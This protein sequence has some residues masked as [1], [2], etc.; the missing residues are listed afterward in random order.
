MTKST[1]LFLSF[2]ILFLSTYSFGQNHSKFSFSAGIGTLPT[3]FADDA[4]VNTPPVNARLTYHA[5]PNFSLSAYAGYSS[6]TTNSP[7]VVSDGQLS[8]L[9]NKQTVAGLRGEMKKMVGKKFKVYGGALLGYSFADKR[10]FDKVT[11]E[12]IE[13]KI[14][15]PTP[16]DPNASNKTFLYS[17]FVGTT[18]YFTKGIGVFAEIGYGISLL[19]TGVT[20]NI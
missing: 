10:E 11:G 1:Q 17:G 2:C 19:N 16:Y 9:E 20:L 3:F 14:D 13:R 4:T 6:A 8:L 18:Y 12:T 5:S 15:G 7:R